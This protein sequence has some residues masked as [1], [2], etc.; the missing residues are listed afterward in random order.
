MTVLEMM[1]TSQPIIILM[2]TLLLL[3]FEMS[4]VLASFR[5]KR[6]KRLRTFY[7]GLFII[8][9][10]FVFYPLLFLNWKPQRKPLPGFLM[11]YGE[12]V[13]AV[14][15]ILFEVLSAVI[16]VVGIGDLHRYRKSHLTPDCIKETMD[17]LPVGIAFARPEGTVVLHNQAMND[18]ARKLTGKGI[19]DIKA[20]REAI[21]EESADDAGDGMQITL[22]DGSS[23]WM[24]SFEDLELDGEPYI[25]LTATDITEQTAVTKELEEKNK[26]L[27][28]INMRLNIYNKQADRIIIAQEL[29]TARM[30][31]H[32]EVGNVLL[33]TRHYL[34]DPASIDEEVLLQA[35]KNTNTYLLKEYEEDDTQSDPL[36]E[37]VEM[38][39]A[40]GVDVVITGRIPSDDPY[41]TVLAAAVRECASNTVKHANGNQLSVE[42]ILI[43]RSIN[44]SLQDVNKSTQDV[45]LSEAKDL[46]M[47]FTNNGNP[48]NGIIR[49]SGGLHSLRVL[50][51]RSGGT[52]QLESVPDFKLIIS[53]P[54]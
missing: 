15:I 18:L 21:H 51:E 12:S 4:L 33:E 2:I 14:F 54:T 42:V 8:S 40:I 19:S 43:P 38:A 53:L 27:R 22:P 24:L 44:K 41:R 47:T 23:S 46:I 26:K 48:P 10:I 39:E 28:D 3:T 6:S 20:F 36:T 25:Q 49:E 11:A 32:N 34:K 37:A 16:I 29:L 30:A 31:V 17:L 35:L 52:M 45:I 1:D 9:L 7:A 13:P 50:V 5:N